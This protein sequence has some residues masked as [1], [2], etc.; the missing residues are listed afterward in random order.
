MKIKITKPAEWYKNLVGTE[1][2]VDVVT[3]S[4]VGTHYEV[5]DFRNVYKELH[6][7]K[8][9]EQNEEEH[10][11]ALSIHMNHACIINT[12]DDEM[13]MIRNSKPEHRLFKSDI[14]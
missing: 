2:E 9:P 8:Y 11:I 13:E 12:T 6:K 14:E 4:F 7:G 10:L 3:R 1:F 5:R